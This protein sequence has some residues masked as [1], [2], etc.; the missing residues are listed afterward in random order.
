MT[1]VANAVCLFLCVCVCVV[2]DG[3]APAITWA[4]GLNLGTRK[5]LVATAAD[6]FSCHYLFPSPSCQDNNNKSPKAVKSYK[7]QS[8]FS[9]TSPML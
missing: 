1:N 3:R 2:L 6:Y 7:L 5:C 9:L 8:I 4:L